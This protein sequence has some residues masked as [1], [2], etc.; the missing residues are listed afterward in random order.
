MWKIVENVYK[1]G[2]SVIEMEEGVEEKKKDKPW[3]ESVM[4]RQTNSV[5]LHVFT[6]V[7]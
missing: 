4:K 6:A 3:N 2:E 1:D 5:E 7:Y